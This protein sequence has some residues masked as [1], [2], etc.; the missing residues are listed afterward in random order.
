MGFEK[1]IIKYEEKRVLWWA[2]SKKNSF[3]YKGT[4][5]IWVK[6]LLVWF[7]GETLTFIKIRI[8]VR[9]VLSKENFSCTCILLGT[10]C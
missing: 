8:K 10:E 6:E 2:V 5:C 9:V 1:L 3:I 7:E 4:K